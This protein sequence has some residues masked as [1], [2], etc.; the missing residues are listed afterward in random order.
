MRLKGYQWSEL[1]GIAFVLVATA[2]QIFYLE[3]L[4]REIEW[5]LAVFYQQQNGQVLARSVF[6]NR[7]AILKAVKAPVDQIKEAT[8]ERA[9]LLSRYKN[10]DANVSGVILSKENVE[11]YLQFLV[12]GLFALGTLLTALGRAVEMRSQNVP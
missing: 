6:D 7:I 1:I 9:K 8:A 12:I 10:A 11:S 2:A 4:K 5:R 3:P